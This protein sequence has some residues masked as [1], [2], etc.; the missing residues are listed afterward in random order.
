ME[1]SLQGNLDYKCPHSCQLVLNNRCMNWVVVTGHRTHRDRVW[2]RGQW[3][4][5]SHPVVVNIRRTFGKT[6]F[7]LEVWIG[8]DIGIGWISTVVFGC[9]PLA[10][11]GQINRVFDEAVGGIGERLPF[12]IINQI[13]GVGGILRREAASSPPSSTLVS[14]PCGMTCCLPL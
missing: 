5:R 10:G 2:H 12:A 1:R 11:I 14:K 9:A 4:V 3:L 6:E 8:A 7:L 13:G